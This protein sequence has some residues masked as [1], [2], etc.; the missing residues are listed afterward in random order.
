MRR[1]YYAGVLK[2]RFDCITRIN[3]V[4]PFKLNFVTQVKLNNKSLN[5]HNK[6]KP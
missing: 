6:A 3:F 2:A 4:F 5:L 1:P